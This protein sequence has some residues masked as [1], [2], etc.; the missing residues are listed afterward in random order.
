MH[1]SRDQ[2]QWFIKLNGRMYP[3]DCGETFRLYI[4]KTLFSCRLEL[5]A[6]WYVIVQET[7]FVLHPTTV[8]S[9]SM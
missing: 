9:V 3:L 5:D 2:D 4:G 8:Y 7:P 6:D 1:Y